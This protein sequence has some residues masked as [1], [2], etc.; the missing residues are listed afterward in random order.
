MTLVNVSSA[1]KKDEIRKLLEEQTGPSYKFVK[2][3]TAIE[4]QFEVTGDEGIKDIASYT[5]KLITS[6]PW[7]KVLMLRVLIEGQ[8]FTGG[9]V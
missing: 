6:T 1:L 7:G 9:K 2:M 5:K 3:K 4:Q 8:A